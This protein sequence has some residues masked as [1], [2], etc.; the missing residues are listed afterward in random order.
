MRK[1]LGFIFC[2]MMISILG[3][4]GCSS[5]PYASMR[6]E[7]LDDLSD[8][9]KL[10]ITQDYDDGLTYRYDSIDFKVKVSGVGEDISDSVVVDGGSGSISEPIVTYLGNGVSQITASLLGI[11]NITCDDFSLVVRTL[12]GGKTLKVNF[13]ID[14]KLNDFEFVESKLQAVTSDYSIVLDDIDGLIKK[15]PEKSNQVDFEYS[16]VSPSSAT[17]EV[18]EWSKSP[19][20][21]TDE[22]FYDYLALGYKYADVVTVDG[23]STLVVYPYFMTATD[24]IATDYDGNPIPTTFPQIVTDNVGNATASVHDYIILKAHSLSGNNLADEYLK[25][26]VVPNPGDVV[27]EMNTDTEN[28]DRFEINV[29]KDGIFNVVLLNANSNGTILRDDSA[30]YF[31]ERTLFFSVKNPINNT[32]VLDQYRVVNKFDGNESDSSQSAYGVVNIAQMESNVFKIEAQNV[33]SKVHTFVMENIQYN[34]LFSR[35]VKVRFKVI[36]IPTSS[37]MTIDASDPTTVYDIYPANTYGTKIAIN[38]NSNFGYTVAIDSQDK[39]TLGS[40]LLVRR[41]GDGDA[42]TMGVLNLT[43][44]T[45]SYID[46]SKVKAKFSSKSSFFL[47]YNNPDDSS[48]D[49]LS[50]TYTIYIVV[51][52]S[53]ADDSYSDDIIEE[54]FSG[55]NLLCFP[56]NITFQKGIGSVAPVQ[57]SYSINLSNSAYLYEEDAS[58][59]V[60]NPLDGFKLLT[61]PAGRSFEDTIASVTYD[62]SFIKVY[63]YQDDTNNVTSLY[64]KYLSTA[65]AD[66]ST[67]IIITAHNGLVGRAS[68]STYVP[69][70]YNVETLEDMPLACDINEYSS[71]FLYYMTGKDIDSHKA[72]YQL[73]KDGV[74]IP[75]AQYNS[76]KTLFLIVNQ[77]QII[78]FYDYRLIEA[79]GDYTVEAVNITDKVHVSFIGSGIE[80]ASYSNGVIYTHGLFTSNYLLPVQMVVSYDTGYE[81][82]DSDGNS[83]FVPVTITHV[84]NIY[85]YEPLEGVE[86]TSSKEVGLY[87]YDSLGYYNKDLSKHTIE[88]TFIPKKVELGSQWNDNPLWGS[89]EDWDPVELSYDYK[90]ALNS[91]ILGS[92]QQEIKIKSRMPGGTDHLLLYKD[93]FRVNEDSSNY[94]CGVECVMSDDLKTWLAENGYTT[95]EQVNYVLKQIFNENIEFVVYVNIQQFNKIVNINSVRFTANYAER[96]E[97]LKLDLDDD[98]AYFEIRNGEVSQSLEISYTINNANV[99][100][101]NIM[102][103]NDLL[104]F[105]EVKITPNATGNGGKIIITPVRAGSGQLTVT[106]KDN[107]KDENNNYYN[108][109]STLVQSFRIKIADGSEDYPFEIRSAEDYQ[110]MILD[111]QNGHYYH[112][113]ITRDLNLSGYNVN[114]INIDNNVGDEFYLTGKHTY[115]RNGETITKY[116]TIYNLSIEQT[117]GNVSGDI[118]VGLFGSLGNFVTLDNI[119]ISNARIVLIDNAEGDNTI[120]V[121]ILAGISYGE[122]NA[123]SVSGTIKIIRNFASQNQ[124]TIIV[125][126]MVG[127]LGLSS[128]ISGLPGSYE[129]G[130]VATGNNAYVDIELTTAK[131][132][133]TIKSS[134]TID[135]NILGGLVGKTLG[136]EVSEVQ[137][138]SNITSELRSTIGGVVG[139]VAGSG[140]KNELTDIYVVPSIVATFSST[141][142]TRTNALDIGGVAGRVEGSYAI[143]DVIVNY[144]STDTTDVEQKTNIWITAS[145]NNE[146]NVGGM[147]GK[148]NAEG[149]ISQSYLRSFYEMDIATNSYYGSIFVFADC[150]SVGGLVGSAYNNSVINKSYFDGDIVVS[151]NLTAGMLIGYVNLEN[152]YK[153]QYAYGIGKMYLA[154]IDD[155][156]YNV[157]AVSSIGNYGIIGSASG[158]YASMGDS[159]FGSNVAEGCEYA[160]LNAT[161]VYAVVNGNI[162]Y[163]LKGKIVYAINNVDSDGNPVALNQDILTLFGKL[164]YKITNGED[165]NIGDYNWFWYSSINTAKVGD[166]TL[167]YPVLFVGNKVM[168]D[169]IPTGIDVI[170]N[171]RAGLYD[172]TYNN[173]L[174]VIMYLNRYTSGSNDNTYYE[175]ALNKNTASFEIKLNGTTTISTTYIQSSHF[176]LYDKIE[177]LEDSQE[178]ILRISGNKIYPVSTGS[179]VI[180]IRSYA[181][182]SVKVDIRV[183]VV[184]GITDVNIDD[185]YQVEDGDLLG[186]EDNENFIYIDEQSKI[187]LSATNKNSTYMANSQYGFVLELLDAGNNA[188]IKIGNTEYTYD[189][190][191]ISKNILMFNSRDIQITGVKLGYIKWVI[192]PFLMLGDEV[193]YLDTYTSYADEG[194]SVTKENVYFLNKAIANIQKVYESSIIAKASQIRNST[195]SIRLNTSVGGVAFSTNIQ[196]ANIS[197]LQNEDGSYRVTIFEDLNISI[198]KSWS[199]TLNLSN[200]TFNCTLNGNKYICEDMQFATSMTDTNFQYALVNILF[201]N[202]SIE[203]S[204]QVTLKENTYELTLSG[205]IKFN[206]A[207]YKAN[208]DKYDINNATYS[209]IMTPSSNSDISATTQITVSPSELQSIFTNF[210]S[211][212]NKSDSIYN[213]YPEDN[214]SEFIVPGR[215]GLLKITLDSEINNGEFNNSSY[216]TITL[217]KKY[218]GLVTLQQLS[219]IVD[220]P[221][222]ESNETGDVV[223]YRNVITSET[224]S[225]DDFFGIKLS[226]LSINYSDTNYF[227]NTYY[228]KITV[229]S[230][231]TESS[232]DMNITSYTRSGNTYNQ[233]LTKAFSLSIMQLPYVSATV[234]GETQ[235]VMG[236]G[237]QKELNIATKGVQSNIDFDII[238]YDKDNKRISNASQYAYI[239]DE[240]GDNVIELDLDYIA[241]GKKYYLNQDVLTPSG[242]Q[243]NLIFTARETIL[244]ILEESNCVLAFTTVDF[245]IDSVTFCGVDNDGKLYL[246]FGENMRLDVQISVKDIKV[247]SEDDINEYTAIDGELAKLLKLACYEFAGTK[248]TN[249]ENGLEQVKTSGNLNLWIRDNSITSQVLYTAITEEGSYGGLTL[250]KDIKKDGDTVL[251]YYEILG[252]EISD[253][254]YMQLD[255]KYY[256]DI[257]GKL[258][259]GEGVG[260]AVYTNGYTLNFTV[261]VEDNSTY[262]HPTPVEDASKLESISGVEGGNFILVNNI[263]LVNWKPQEAKFATLDGNG[264]TITIKSFDF[265]DYKGVSSTDI[266]I[267]STISEYSLLKN[268]IVDISPLLVSEQAM[269]NN[270][271]NIDLRN[272]NTLNFGIIAGT[273]NGAITN[274]KI[275]STKSTS[276]TTNDQLKSDYLHVLTTQGTSTSNIGGMVGLNASSG[277]ITNSF[278]GVN[279]SNSKTVEV[280]SSSTVKYYIE[281]VSNPSATK[282]DN[283]T[284]DLEEVEIYPFVLAGGNILGG[285]V[286]INDGVISSS[287]AKGLG[288]HNVNSTVVGD[289][290]SATAGLVT[291]NNGIITSSFVEGNEIENYRAVDNKFRLE[292]TG[293][294]GGLVYQNNKTI[295]N[296]YTNAY[297]QN[298]ASYIGGFV[299]QNNQGGTIANCYTTAVNGN[300][301]AIGQFTG[302]KQGV[303]QNKGI[304]ENCYYLIMN[305][306]ELASPIEDAIE[307]VNADNPF[308]SFTSWS[309]FSFVTGA[310]TDGIWTLTE[311]ETPK[312]AS[313]LTDTISFR[314]ILNSTEGDEGIV[315]DYIYDTYYLGSKENP[316]I[317]GSKENSQLEEGDGNKDT[318]DKYIIDNTFAYKNSSGTEDMIFGYREGENAVRYVRLVNNLD[319]EDLVFANGYKGTNLYKIIFAGVLDGNGMTIS[320]LNLNNTYEDEPLDNFG[321]FGQ[322][323]Y[324]GSSSKAVVKNINISVNSFSAKGNNKT[325]I[326]AGTIVNSSIVNVRIDGGSTVSE[327]NIVSGVNMA[328]ALAGLIYADETSNV[329]IID[330]EISNVRVSSAYNGLSGTLSKPKGYFYDEFIVLKNGQASTDGFSFT[331]LYESGE[332][333]LSNSTSVSYAGGVA[334]VIVANNYTTP[335]SGDA[336]YSDYRTKSNEST[337]SNVVVNGQLVVNSEYNAGGLFGYIGENTLVRNS[338]LIVSEDQLIKGG[339]FIGGI[340]GE[341]HGVIEEC[342]VSYT[343]DMNQDENQSIYDSTILS[344]DRTNGTFNLFDMSTGTDY[345]TVSVGGIAGYSE[346]G[347]I[348]DSYSKVNVVKSLSFIAGGI[349]GYAKNYNYLGFVY[350]T[351]TVYARDIIGGIIGLQVNS[352]EKNNS[353]ISIGNKTYLYNVVS[354]TNWNAS[355]DNINIRDEITKRLYN[356][357][358]IIYQSDGNVNFY[359]KMPEVGN[360]NIVSNTTYQENYRIASKSSYIGS[361]VGQ[362]LLNGGGTPIMG[363]LGTDNASISLI[364]NNTDNILGDL[365]AD[366]Y[367]VFSATL[368]LVYTTGD[369]ASGN[370]I[371][372][373]FKESFTVDGGED[374][375]INSLSY[376]TAYPTTLNNYDLVEEDSKYLDKFT[377]AQIFTSQEYI[378]QLLGVS[379]SSNVDESEGIGSTLSSRNIFAFGYSDDRFSISTDENAEGK[380]VDANAGIW[381]VSTDTEDDYYY[382]PKSAGGVVRSRVDV[383]DVTTLKQ[384]FS[385]SSTGKTY[386]IQNDIT[387]NLGGEGIVQYYGGIKSLFVGNINDTKPTIT[388][389]VSNLATIF[390]LL[391]GTVFQD[392]DFVINASSVDVDENTAIDGDNFG[393]FANTLDSVQIINCDFDI[394]VNANVEYYTSQNISAS[395]MGVLFGAINNSTIKNSQFAVS[396]GTIKVKEGVANFGLL[397]GSISRSSFTNVEISLENTQIE[398]STNSTKLGVGGVSGYVYNSK[399]NDI[400]ID[401]VITLSISDYSNSSKAIAGLFGIA[402]QLNLNN[403]SNVPSLKYTINSDSDDI[404]TLNLALVVGES[405]ASKISG[406]IIS[407]N[408]SLSASG[409]QSNPIKYYNVGSIIGKD[410]K[411][412]QIG[413]SGVVGSYATL[414]SELDAYLLN[415]GGLVGYTTESY[416]LINNAFVDGSITITNNNKKS[417]QE[418]RTNDK[419]EVVTITTCA[420]TYVGGLLGYA[421]GKVS[422]NSVANASVITLNISTEKTSKLS[423]NAGQILASVGGLVGGAN[424]TISI[425]EFASIGS[426][427]LNKLNYNTDIYPTYLS[428]VLGYNQGVLVASNGYSY[429]QLPRENTVTTACLSI[430]SGVISSVNNVYYTQEFVGNSED[431]DVMF[432][433]FAMADLYDEISTYSNIY[434][435]NDI[436][437]V[438]KIGDMCFYLPSSLAGNGYITRTGSNDKFHPTK[439]TTLSNSTITSKYNVIIT[440]ISNCTTNNSIA[441]NCIVSG[442]NISTGKV[443]LGF[444]SS[445]TTDIQYLFS[446][447]NG[448]LSNVY[449]CVTGNNTSAVNKY[450]LVSVNNG[451]ITNVMVYGIT[452]ANY[453]FAETNNGYIYSSVSSIKYSPIVG[454]NGE[455]TPLYGLVNINKGT[456][457]DCYSSSFA[458]VDDGVVAQTEVYGFANENSGKIE[459]SAYYV[460]TSMLHDNKVVG[461]VRTGDGEVNTCYNDNTSSVLLSRSNVWYKEDGHVQI[462]GMKDI[463]DSIITKIFITIDSNTTYIQSVS[464]LRSMIEKAISEGKEYSLSYE[465]AFYQA[466]AIDKPTYNVVRICTGEELVDYIASLNNGYI[467]ANTIVLLTNNFALETSNIINVVATKLNRISLSSSTTALIGINT[468]GSANMTLDFSTGID[469]NNNPVYGVMTHELFNENKGLIIGIDICNISFTQSSASSWFAPIYINYGIISHVN[470]NRYSVL[471]TMGTTYVSGMV[472]SCERGIIHSSSVD[473]VSITA[474]KLYNFICNKVSIDYDSIKW[475]VSKPNNSSVS[476]GEEYSKGL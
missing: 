418:N 395:N 293:N 316:L 180:T 129:N 56:I 235:L 206:R 245:E 202:M 398:V 123:C 331:S 446:S 47:K 464:D 215:D 362:A 232:L 381:E 310:N 366:S 288:V 305:S 26:E 276:D 24:E 166:T 184:Y 122:I 263:E 44:K 136:A 406:V 205:T 226:K 41:E 376:R 341:N 115:T 291:Y 12:E 19:T 295:E 179:A 322:I 40:V 415:A 223:G 92:S 15:I 165:S 390:N 292:S 20:F 431:I 138:I 157:Q 194:V 409:T 340:V 70:I 361:V 455:I 327:D 231:I 279:I 96:I 290:A 168:Y 332:T 145:A 95:S 27:L 38:T 33:G 189:S 301:Y 271:S 176:K 412:S 8:V 458:Y 401:N 201:K 212:I 457:R 99:V 192:T 52:Y 39:D 378:Q 91:P 7:S 371:D 275:V 408:N 183:L 352:A 32:G 134:S 307:I 167:A 246:K 62:N 281:T 154:T 333:K 218:E 203:K 430:S 257:S 100:N 319:C 148:E 35:E 456:I 112:Y 280:N 470:F 4:L 413:K 13:R 414:T 46:D 60:V 346:N 351:G 447:N 213:E 45:M 64:I 186:S 220:S 472:Y 50:G 130:I 258:C 149:S 67:N 296:S 144:L 298:N 172:I 435:L 103:F 240:N 423:D 126:G 208:A 127:S 349:V 283:K 267:F 297:I 132:A 399:L 140:R 173:A 437:D 353:T 402:D 9:Q 88:S 94:Q 302:V 197:I 125:G 434:A 256:Y 468:E 268:I 93:L 358:S 363:T 193:D 78:N 317:I 306:D 334:G 420:T 260:S 400:V 261:I 380:F 475:K 454:V 147:I 178:K 384:A 161:D 30:A 163:F 105:Y 225:G 23:K 1:R 222:G 405:T 156:K 465:Y 469:G 29:D 311:G 248:L 356:N 428:G 368:G 80:Y 294:I 448:I 270:I 121:G 416:W 65:T 355:N 325:G 81:D 252:S 439:I 118:G 426:V 344:N 229:R 273:N 188:T 364:F 61:L 89:G 345:Y 289:S 131:D 54:Y 449:V 110:K 254:N 467:P 224:V 304:Y 438:E 57:D 68:V 272:I 278:M 303:L 265:S 397:A 170:I 417:Q 382:L 228:I 214:E 22:S 403:I 3:F 336:D 324:A 471:A 385:N 216:I 146:V 102:Y 117:I 357:Q 253:N 139:L 309:G 338:S 354:L 236:K 187:V 49:L 321:L 421:D 233:Q 343:T 286:S 195:S 396:V 429:V 217:D 407:S 282:L 199:G 128:S 274:A 53:I 314:R 185:M 5:D 97:E 247:G 251:E 393:L 58:G 59:E 85:I 191:N 75:D 142:G 114:N 369:I 462:V 28:S 221:V 71:A 90:S 350:N 312:I 230:S 18:D 104:T 244:G 370:R 159:I 21:T 177:I 86:I 466:S 388:I 242:T 299:Y 460:E 347:I 432:G 474:G 450:A 365:Y 204:R 120:S 171:E 36:D 243:F 175:L 320:N 196:T 337:I 143:S 169:I 335:L 182:S 308:D 440:S 342:T 17:G 372:D 277:A 155:G 238:A 160:G 51:S 445:N 42:C 141:T 284:D 55:E 318:F 444:N 394:N 210:Y 66:Q 37:S 211:K 6:L 200:V 69:T 219:A 476:A 76:I 63:Q 16:I 151:G 360:A 190:T 387:W 108:S 262:D 87:I 359:I 98:G 367:G 234:D 162:N 109:S 153:V 164:G 101:K 379:Y 463:D 411:N 473:N 83:I 326:L 377:F 11:D 158:S 410:N 152:A 433:S 84:I 373:Y 392:V 419:G 452:S 135:S 133:V 266:G 116:S 386:V 375:S 31:Y 106:P 25:V 82:F 250:I 174:Q 323:G 111:I 264:Y 249:Y 137:V 315:Y 442:R 425:D 328:G 443:V 14:I 441:D 79:D 459:Y 237:V 287:Y 198:N 424:G 285:L 269:S 48:N 77:E 339:N 259:L 74:E 73:R 255:V 207:E 300:S 461:A 124:R 227:N 453:V 427:T 181:V 239:T 389:N 119:Y 72:L 329:S 107:I 330:V 422:L 383:T 34:E 43:S 2:L 10:S 451:L 436:M 404:D 113:I 209:V 391:Y 374:N 348:L 241:S 313:T 150:G